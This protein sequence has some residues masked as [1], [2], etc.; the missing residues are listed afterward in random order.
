MAGLGAV[1]NLPIKDELV[2]LLSRVEEGPKSRCVVVAVKL[3]S[4]IFPINR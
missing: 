3:Y 1:S 4:L 2:I